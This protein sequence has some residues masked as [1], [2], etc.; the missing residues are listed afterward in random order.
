MRIA[1]YIAGD[2]HKILELFELVFKQKM[3]L[4]YWIWRF[5]NNPAGAKM[6][7]LMWDGDKLVG[8]YAVSPLCM[9]VNNKHVL[10]AHSMTTMTHPD[11]G[12][13]GIFKLLSLA[14][15]EEIENDLGCEAVW[16]FPNN[17]SHYGFINSLQWKNIAIIHTMGI[18]PQKLIVSNKD[19]EVEE[20]EL[21]DNEKVD[22]IQ[23]KIDGFS[24]SIHRS[25]EYLNW[26]YCE[27]PSVSY[28]KFYFKQKEERA[29]IIT[30]IYPSE[31]KNV[32]DLNI[33]EDQIENYELIHDYLDYIVKSYNCSFNRITLWKN[34]FDEDHL[35]LEK[36][37]FTLTTPQTY[38]CSRSNHAIA[39]QFNDYRNWYISMG[40]SDVY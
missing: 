4:D 31:E 5:L 9:N 26:R 37:G 22:F 38:L 27:N 35:K 32:F 15:Y 40:D 3:S 33:V 1:N 12:G 7:K 25:K 23:T 24:V 21:F 39:N 10:T 16:G 20:F 36:K 19:I 18:S 2:E 6:I 14:L 8:H 34:I 13:R 29:V 30:K 11:Y 28:K 17:N